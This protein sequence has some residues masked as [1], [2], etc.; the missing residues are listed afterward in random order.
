MPSFPYFTS[1]IHCNIP[2]AKPFSIAPTTN[3]RSCY[4]RRP[5]IVHNNANG[6]DGTMGTFPPNPN[7]AED[8]VMMICD[9]DYNGASSSSNGHASSSFFE[10]SNGLGNDYCPHSS[11][12][13]PLMEV[14]DDDIPLMPSTL[15]KQTAVTCLTALAEAEFEGS[16]G[17]GQD[18][19]TRA[20]AVS[21]VGGGPLFGS[22]SSTL[23]AEASPDDEWGQFAHHETQFARSTGGR[24]VRLHSQRR[25]RRR[26]SPAKY[27]RH[28]SSLLT[29][30]A[31]RG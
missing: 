25:P 27:D 17:S 13:F 7:D 18:D 10:Q 31:W 21:V 29:S 4:P 24:R 12:L 14:A 8:E 11:E 6:S 20:T 23:V 26:R 9:D 30:N 28:G 3:K 22:S 19:F 15:R 5:V 1:K 16:S 2:P